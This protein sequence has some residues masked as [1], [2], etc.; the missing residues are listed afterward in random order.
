MSAKN[1][2]LMTQLESIRM[3]SEIYSR[4]LADLERYTYT[5]LTAQ[6][7]SKTDPENITDFIYNGASVDDLVTVHKKL[8]KKPKKS[9]K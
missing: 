1:S 4:A 7:M 9:K 6:G 8:N 3:A 5:V 2:V